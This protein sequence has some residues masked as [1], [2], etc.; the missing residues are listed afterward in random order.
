MH[1]YDICA[2]TTHGLLALGTSAD[3]TVISFGSGSS[4][5]GNFNRLWGEALIR[6]DVGQVDYFAMLH[7]DIG[8]SEGWLDTLLAEMKRVDADVI[9]AVAAFKDGS[10]ITSTGIGHPNY[11]WSPLHRFTVPECHEF[12]PPTFGQTDVEAYLDRVEREGTIVSEPGCREVNLEGDK[13]AYPLLVNTGCMLV[14]LDRPWCRETR[15]DDEARLAF[16]WE[17]RN[18]VVREPIPPGHRPEGNLPQDCE[19]MYRSYFDS[20]DWRASRHWHRRGVRVF[21]TT[22]VSVDHYGTT[23]SGNQWKRPTDQPVR[24]SGS[25]VGSC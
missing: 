6:N 15:P 2:A 19:V 3:T 8:P 23:R 13:S 25:E 14:R 21:A 20:E 9:S 22:A 1:S 5:T 18:K 10:E 11:D 17:F 12:F 24:G 7:S 4:L 16:A